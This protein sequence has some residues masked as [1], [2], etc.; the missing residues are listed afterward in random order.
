MQRT[1][2]AHSVDG[3]CSIM[4]L[5]AG[6]KISFP[7]A[8]SFKLLSQL[9]ADEN[10]LDQLGSASLMVHVITSQ[11]SDHIWQTAEQHIYTFEYIY[12][13]EK[14][15]SFWWSYWFLNVRPVFFVYV[16]SNLRNEW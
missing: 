10:W 7:K 3:S 2:T 13:T 6:V 16:C 8:V 1:G 4:L 12:I 14:Q 15:L 5:S 11:Y 9:A